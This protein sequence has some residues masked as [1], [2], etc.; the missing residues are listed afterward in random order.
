MKPRTTAIYTFAL[1]T[2]LVEFLGHLTDIIGVGRT[3]IKV[4]K[5]NILALIQN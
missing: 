1:C 5:M 3:G 4:Y 2:F